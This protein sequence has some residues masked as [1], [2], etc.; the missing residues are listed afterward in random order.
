MASDEEVR[1]RIDEIEMLKRE[2]TNLKSKVRRRIKKLEKTS[3]LL[4]RAR[5]EFEIE[6]LKGKIRRWEVAEIILSTSIIKAKSNI[7]EKSEDKIDWSKAG[8]A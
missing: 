2:I 1:K 8:R 5:I 7:S 6:M 3:D 4:E